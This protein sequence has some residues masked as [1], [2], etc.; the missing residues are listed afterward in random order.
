MVRFASWKGFNQ[1]Q[2]QLT[3]T[4]A[5]W[6]RML[7][8]ALI[9][10]TLSVFD[11]LYLPSSESSK[12]WMNENERM[13]FHEILPW[14]ELRFY[15]IGPPSTEEYGDVDVRSF[16]F[17]CLPLNKCTTNLI[18]FFGHFSWYTI[19]II[20]IQ[21]LSTCTCAECDRKI[22]VAMRTF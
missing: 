13:S 21:H 10:H 2:S 22:A 12:Y 16:A 15:W 9:A 8:L 19:H 18:K 4:T 3:E 6:M 20:N 11:P 17:T 14:H 1:I 7:Q 5:I